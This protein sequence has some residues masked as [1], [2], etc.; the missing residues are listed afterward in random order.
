VGGK[1]FVPRGRLKWGMCGELPLLEGNMSSYD[2]CST[3]HW[4]RHNAT[5]ASPLLLPSRTCW[6]CH[7]SGT[8]P[9][10]RGQVLTEPAQPGVQ[11]TTEPGPL[12]LNIT[13]ILREHIR[14][15]HHIPQPPHPLTWLFVPVGGNEP[16]RMAVTERQRAGTE[17]N[18][19]GPHLNTVQPSQEHNLRMGQTPE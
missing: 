4:S 10:R 6:S 15:R 8:K 18:R 13:L 3:L 11:H 19:N 7:T 16:A 5:I 17:Q 2:V 1:G 14:I 9:N 12:T